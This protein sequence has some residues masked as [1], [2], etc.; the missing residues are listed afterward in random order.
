MK[1]V[2]PTEHSF[3][4]SKSSIFTENFHQIATDA[5]I[6]QNF[7]V[8]RIVTQIKSFFIMQFSEKMHRSLVCTTNDE[9]ETS[10]GQGG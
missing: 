3:I 10:T 5:I 7:A 9:G 4:F 2:M 8:V 1:K 6:R